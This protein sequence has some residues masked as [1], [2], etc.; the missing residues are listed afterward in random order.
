MK[1][2]KC[3]VPHVKDDTILETLSKPVKEDGGIR[4]KH[5][6]LDNQCN[7]Q[8]DTDNNR[9]KPPQDEIYLCPP[10]NKCVNIIAVK[11]FCNKII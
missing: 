1:N 11:D 8:V 3:F 7:E 6:Y 4:K 2:S 5:F 10:R 9:D